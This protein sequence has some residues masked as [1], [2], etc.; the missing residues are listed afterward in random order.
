MRDSDT[1]KIEK[2]VIFFWCVILLSVLLIDGCCG[3][4]LFAVEFRRAEPTLGDVHAA[5]CRVRVSNARGTGIFNGYNA[6][7]N[8]AYISTNDHVTTNNG[9]CKLDF[10]TNAKME[11]VDGRVVYSLRDD[12][13]SRDFAIIAVDADALKKIDPPYIPMRAIQLNALR[14]RVFYSSGCPDGRFDQGFKGIIESTDGGMAIFS[15]PPVPGQ[16]GSGICVNIDGK[17]YDVAKLTYL[18]GTKGADESKGG[19]LPLANLIT[20]AGAA[21]FSAVQYTK[22]PVADILDDTQEPAVQA[23]AA[24]YSLGRDNGITVKAPGEPEK[25]IAVYVTDP[26]SY[27]VTPEIVASRQPPRGLFQDLLRDDGDDDQPKD[28]DAQ[29]AT[30]RRKDDD[31]RRWTPGDAITDKIEDKVTNG[32]YN[33]FSAII[34]RVVRIIFWLGVAAT[35]V[36]LFLAR[37]VVWLFKSGSKWFKTFIVAVKEISAKNEDSRPVDN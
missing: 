21:S 33:A 13:A 26:A 9:S 27:D 18:L 15:P 25:T 16:S 19:A 7:A 23:G 37:S 12:R 6:A 22:T 34:P 14:G 32:I 29:E 3:E 8:V 17:I 11:T 24:L 2:R 35:V 30:P 36:G 28:D 10:W 20:D 31:A 1:D 4:R 5:S